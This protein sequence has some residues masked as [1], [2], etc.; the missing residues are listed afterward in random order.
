MGNFADSMQRPLSIQTG[1]NNL[2]TLIEE[3]RTPRCEAYRFDCFEASLKLGALLQKGQRLRVQALPFKM[4]VALLERPG[5]LVSKEELAHRL[6]GQ[7][8]FTDID[9]SLYVMAG[10]LRQV[11]GDDASQPRFIKTDSGKGYRFIASVTPVFATVSEGSAP[12][13]LP[14]EQT[15]LTVKRT[16]RRAA[17][18]L[19]AVVIVAALGTGLAAYKYEHR[20]LMNDHDGVVVAGIANSTGNADLD[21]TF[22]SALHSQL[23]QS[24]YLN[25]ISDTNFR[26]LIKSPESASLQDELRACVKLEGLVLLMGC[27]LSLPHR[28]HVTLIAWICFINATPTTEKAVA[29]S[30]A[31]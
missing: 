20:A 24:P 5:E 1:E 4:L 12:Q 15:E 26:A 2:S 23:E 25:L 3:P 16:S 6:W 13:S 19:L 31:T 7:S 14:A 29:S 10:K 18:R 21:G 30:Q 11:L 27:I 28:Y 8:I 22:S 17:L 9:Q